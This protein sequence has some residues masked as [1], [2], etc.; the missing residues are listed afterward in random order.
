MKYRNKSPRFYIPNSSI[1]DGATPYVTEKIQKIVKDNGGKNIRLRNTYD[2]SNLP[3]VV[4]FSAGTAYL[5]GIEAA[6]N[7]EF[8]TEWIRVDNIANWETKK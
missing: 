1:F 2:L 7:K 6:L 4:T 8:N 3:K 5:D